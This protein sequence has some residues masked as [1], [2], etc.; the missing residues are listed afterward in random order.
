MAEL[1]NGAPDTRFEDM[2]YVKP[3]TIAEPMRSMLLSAKDDDVLPPVTTSAGVELYAVCARRPLGGNE[4]R[5]SAAM[6]QLQ[7]KELDVLA[8]RALRN[9]RQEANIEYK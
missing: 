3:G 1:A 8:R 7:S 4:E 6:A 9:L 2:K 5:R